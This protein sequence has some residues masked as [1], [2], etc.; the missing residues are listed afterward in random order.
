MQA[1]GSV[2]VSIIAMHIHVA[3]ADGMQTSFTWYNYSFCADT[4]QE[5]GGIRPAVY[6]RRQPNGK[7]YC[8]PCYMQAAGSVHVS[9]IRYMLT[10]ILNL[11]EDNL[12]RLVAE[13]QEMIRLLPGATT[14]M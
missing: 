4:N 3:N 12:T 1:A 7:L 10:K 8:L 2:H 13:Q 14:E 6:E 11:K 5:D 9:I